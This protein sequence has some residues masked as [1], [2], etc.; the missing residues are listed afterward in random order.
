V[1]ENARRRA[2][3]ACRVVG[4]LL[5][6]AAVAPLLAC[7]ASAPHYVAPGHEGAPGL[8]RVLLCPMNLAQSLPAEIAGGA[9]PVEREL[10]AQLAARGLELERLDLGTG[11]D[12]WRAAVAEA[13]SE[14]AKSAGAYFARRLAERRD[15][16][17]LLLPSLISR[18]V[19]VT[20][21]SGSWDGVRRRMNMVNLPSRGTAGSTDTFSKGVFM[22]GVTG[23]VLATSLHVVVFSREGERIFEGVGGID[24]VHEIDLSRARADFDYDL[25]PRDD[26]P[27]SAEAVHEGVAIALGPYLPPLP[28]P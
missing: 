26:L 9:P 6:N 3:Q 27:G 18:T 17:A 7:T 21:N 13:R 19:R 12:V 11:R 23:A 22:G 10:L 5:A 14:G 16:Q 15:F 1:S 28:G 25:R 2:V 20:D 8:E 24:F 4:R